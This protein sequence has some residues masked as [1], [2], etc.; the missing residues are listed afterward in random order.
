M[1]GAHVSPFPPV[2]L[3]AARAAGRQT[4]VRLGTAIASSPAIAFLP[5]DR[6]V[7]P[8]AVTDLPDSVLFTPPSHRS[9]RGSLSG[10]RTFVKAA[11]P[12]SETVRRSRPA[13]P[14]SSTA[15]LAIG[16]LALV[17]LIL[18]VS[19]LSV[20]GTTEAAPGPEETT[21]EAV[22]STTSP[23]PPTS[24]A[25]AAA[26]PEVSA[27]QFP[28]EATPIPVDMITRLEAASDGPLESELG[29]LLDAMQH[30]F[31]R[32][33]ARLEPT[34]RSYAYRMSSRF[35]WNPD[36]FRV[37]VTAPDPDLAAARAS[38]LQ[39]LF[40]DAVDSGRLTVVSGTGPHALMVLSE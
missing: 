15:I 13:P 34:L 25:P 30:G 23:A 17:C 31:G 36:S 14:L 33:S 11:S 37:S 18:G 21:E 39:R 24:A 22:A 28:A 35:M 16:A 29:H 32:E 20:L 5:L 19:L 40:S 3:A 26:A 38:L 4:H 9:D 2:V 1:R 12:A 8:V 10:G 7:A 27:A 6:P